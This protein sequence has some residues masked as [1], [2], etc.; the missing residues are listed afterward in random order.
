MERSV[1]ESVVVQPWNLNKAGERFC[2]DVT[3]MVDIDCETPE[4]YLRFE[5]L[6][7]EIPLRMR[8]AKNGAARDM[9][10]WQKGERYED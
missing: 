9:L 2:E 4:E 10:S 6:Q 3:D 5:K 1:E 8:Q 7:I